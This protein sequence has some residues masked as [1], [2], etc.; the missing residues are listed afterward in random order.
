LRHNDN[1]FGRWRTE[2]VGSRTWADAGQQVARRSEAVDSLPLR[3]GRCDRGVRVLNYQSADIAPTISLTSRKP[4]HPFKSVQPA[5]ALPQTPELYDVVNEAVA[6]QENCIGTRWSVT[7]AKRMCSRST[8]IP[9]SFV[10]SSGCG[11]RNARQS[12]CFWI[13]VRL[14]PAAG[15]VAYPYSHY[16]A[17]TQKTTF[18]GRGSL[19]GNGHWFSFTSRPLCSACSDYQ[20][21]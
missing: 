20:M 13:G 18:R 2:A 16:V 1:R 10:R 8:A 19:T 12:R 21:A 15:T 3:L 17:K 11:P 9:V 5:Q 7:S 4:W 6:V 14:A